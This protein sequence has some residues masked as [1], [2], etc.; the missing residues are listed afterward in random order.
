MV[1][2]TEV[3]GVRVRT[4]TAVAAIGRVML[5]V[6]PRGIPGVL[7]CR[8]QELRFEGQVATTED[9]RG[10]RKTGAEEGTRGHETG[11]RLQK[12]GPTCVSM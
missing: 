11:A 2:L 7:R 4:A 12:N 8:V 6:A 3:E 1:P 5:D 10:F 9:L